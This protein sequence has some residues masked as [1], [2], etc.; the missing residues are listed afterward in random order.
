M[1]FLGLRYR[2]FFWGCA[3]YANSKE[4]DVTPAEFCEHGT[5]NFVP[6]WGIFCFLMKLS[7]GQGQ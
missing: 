5:K 7:T 2:F 6:S 4:N 3:F 1:F